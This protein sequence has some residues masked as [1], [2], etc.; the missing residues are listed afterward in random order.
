MDERQTSLLDATAK[1]LVQ[2]SISKAFH[3]LST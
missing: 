1:S 2:G 3:S